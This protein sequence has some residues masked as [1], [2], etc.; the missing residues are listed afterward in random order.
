[1]KRFLACLLLCTVLAGC[2]G[3]PLR[4]LPRLMQLPGQLLDANP[5]DF[6]VALQ[7]DARLVPPPGAVPLLRVQ[8]TPRD[9]SAYAPIDKKL[10]L[11]MAVA[12][13]ATQG[14]EPPPPGRRWLVFSLGTGAQAELQQVQ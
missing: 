11:Q 9:P 1:M 5:A 12:S 8:I 14:L 10:P 7:V 6:M 3:V 13:F 4:S 2:T